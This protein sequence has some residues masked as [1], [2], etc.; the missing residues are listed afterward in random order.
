MARIL[1]ATRGL[2]LHLKQGSWDERLPK[3]FAI[4][5]E[6]LRSAQKQVPD[7]LGPE[8]I[9]EGSKLA[10]GTLAAKL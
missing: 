8:D 9:A 3:V 5:E 6:R 10:E 2:A 7:L 4:T 1:T